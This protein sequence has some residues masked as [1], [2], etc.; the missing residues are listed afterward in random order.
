[1][2]EQ[3]DGCVQPQFSLA[4]PQGHI[5]P[6]Y[7][8]YQKSI[9]HMDKSKGRNNDPPE[10]S[11]SFMAQGGSDSGFSY[12]HLGREEG[13]RPLTPPDSQLAQQ[14]FIFPE[15]L[16]VLFPSS[17]AP[18][19]SWVPCCPHLQGPLLGR[20]MKGVVGAS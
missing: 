1:M 12:A 9:R 13:R 19:P 4:H 8:K 18:R 17:P 16:R 3:R 2:T 14:V 15:P 10:L 6:N 20:P 11:S 5:Y 7:L